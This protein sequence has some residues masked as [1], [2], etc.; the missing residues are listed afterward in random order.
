[1]SSDPNGAWYTGDEL[2]FIER[3]A[4]REDRKA[5]DGYRNSI[6]KRA[7]W[8]RIDREKVIQAIENLM[9]QANG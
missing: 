3:I 9:E 6:G 7:D 5:F 4:A 8:G 1:M 2:K